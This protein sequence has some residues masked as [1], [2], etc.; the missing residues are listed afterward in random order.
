MIKESYLDR[1]SCDEIANRSVT[2]PT[3]ESPV[4]GVT[5]DAIPVEIP[6]VLVLETEINLSV[7]NP[8]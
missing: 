2:R 1:K 8:F 4:N 7:L 6:E 3:P 5:F